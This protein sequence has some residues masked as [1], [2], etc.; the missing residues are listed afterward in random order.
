M[1]GSDEQKLNIGNV[2][3]GIRPN[4]TLLRKFDIAN[5]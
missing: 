4:G 2:K 1:Y 5:N 3:L